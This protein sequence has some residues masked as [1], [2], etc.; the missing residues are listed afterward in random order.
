MGSIF[1]RIVNREIPAYIID[2]DGGHLAFLDAM[3]L[4]EGHTLIIPKKETD[5][6]FDLEEKEFRNLWSFARKVARKLGRA[7][8][9]KRVTVSVVGFEVPHAHIHLMPVSEMNEMNFT[10]KRLRFS[11][12]EY[13][14]IRDKIRHTTL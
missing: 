12:E 10:N 9:E 7:Y 2:E 8:P 4:V 13:L 5:W 3:P 11:P 1:T 14:S 6:V